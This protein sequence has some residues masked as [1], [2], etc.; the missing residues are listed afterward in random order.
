MF[1][2]ASLGQ[3]YMAI[4]SK[5]NS[6]AQLFAFFRKRLGKIYI[7]IAPK[8]SLRCHYFMFVYTLRGRPCGDLR[9][10]LEPPCSGPHPP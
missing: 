10:S 7:N 2:R 9:S 5:M 8:T 6:G 3:S 1:F 4:V